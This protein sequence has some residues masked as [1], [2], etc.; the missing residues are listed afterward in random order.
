MLKEWHT[1][2]ELAS[3]QLPEIPQTE[4]G[5]KRKAKKE[6]WRSQPH[7]GKGGGLEYHFHNLPTETQVHLMWLSQQNS[8]LPEPVTGLNALPV[9]PTTAKEHAESVENQAIIESCD[10]STA[11]LTDDER[12]AMSRHF[13]SKPGKM[14]E[15]AF[16]KVRMLDTYYELE[17]QH[18]PR[19]EVLA[20]VCKKYDIGR[21]V[22]Y[23]AIDRVKDIPREL[24]AEAL[25]AKHLGRVKTAACT[26]AAYEWFKTDYL[27][28]EAPPAADS[29]RKLKRVAKEKGWTEIPSLKTLMRWVERDFSPVAIV[30]AREGKEAAM[31]MYPAQ[32]RD[33][34]VFKALQAVNADGHKFDVFVQWEDGSI[35]RPVIVAWQDLMSGKILGWRVDRTENRDVVRLSFGDMVVKY[36]IAVIYGVPGMGK[37]MTFDWFCS[38]GV[39][40]WVY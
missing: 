4:S 30:I 17:K 3:M 16:Q 34:S 11:I 39:S 27:R 19:M 22:I 18:V 23:D 32:Q 29:Y 21:D 38:K 7:Q 15:R 1:A 28:N 6:K 24:W 40:S 31:R 25:I 2:K 20:T 5:I 13:S 10:V 26:P 9:E 35:S 33:K 12:S 14:Q 37:T 36:G 8:P